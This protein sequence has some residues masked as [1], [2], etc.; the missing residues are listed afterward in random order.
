[1]SSRLR[2]N[3]PNPLSKIL[4]GETSGPSWL[5]RQC[6]EFGAG[7]IP[8]EGLFFGFVSWC[9][10]NEALNILTDQK[11]ADRGGWLATSNQ[12]SMIL[13]VYSTIFMIFQFLVDSR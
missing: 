10:I 11:T 12:I 8:H 6:A 13:S 3:T 4:I 9:S 5:K 2:R 1:V 7:G